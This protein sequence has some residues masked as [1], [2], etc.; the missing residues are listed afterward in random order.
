MSRTTRRLRQLQEADRE[1]VSI[2]L[3]G[4]LVG[5]G[6]VVAALLGLI[7]AAAAVAALASM[8]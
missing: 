1:E 2:S 3:R 4:S 5:V 7:A 8:M 6:V